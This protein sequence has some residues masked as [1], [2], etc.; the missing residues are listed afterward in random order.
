MSGTSFDWVKYAADVPFTCLIELR[1]L[2]QY[3][4][5]LPQEQII[6]NSLEIMDFMLEMDRVT[7]SMNYYRSDAALAYYSM[8]VITFSVFILRLL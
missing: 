4:F 5:L 8:M 2:G 6:P 1:D 7:K 3:G